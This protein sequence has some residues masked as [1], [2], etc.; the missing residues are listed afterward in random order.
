MARGLFNLKYCA[1]A[2]ADIIC[3]PQIGKTPIN[4]PIDTAMAFFNGDSFLFKMIFLR[5][6]R[7]AVILNRAHFRFI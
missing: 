3:I 6:N 5:F 4:T 2:T 1:D 7:L